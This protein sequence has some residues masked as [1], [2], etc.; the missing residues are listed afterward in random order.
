L[1]WQLHL[2][3]ARW[4]GIRGQRRGSVFNRRAHQSHSRGLRRNTVVWKVYAGF[5]W[6]ARH[7]RPKSNKTPISENPLRI[8]PLFPHNPVTIWR[9]R[10]ESHCVTASF[11][12]SQPPCKS[13]NYARS[14]V[15]SAS[16]RRLRKSRTILSVAVQ[17]FP[18]ILPVSFYWSFYWRSLPGFVEIS[19]RDIIPLPN[20]EVLQVL[21]KREQQRRTVICTETIR[22]DFQTDQR[23]K[24]ANRQ[25]RSRCPRGQTSL[26]RREVARLPR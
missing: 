5:G 15:K 19:L 1:S 9:R 13:I 7:S 8:P 24:S 4:A 22:P 20:D 18:T 10:S 11:Q 12:S 14:P 23:P 17:N 3:S 2:R 26:L 25:D 16:Q 6:K 21:A